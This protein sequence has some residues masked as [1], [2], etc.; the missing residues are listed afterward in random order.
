M[1]KQKNRRF[2][3]TYFTGKTKKKRLRSS[4]IHVS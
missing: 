4:S 3:H 2:T 1:Q